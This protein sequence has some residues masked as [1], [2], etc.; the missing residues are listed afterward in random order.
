MKK[1]RGITLIALVITIIVLLILAGVS[2]SLI[3]G[4]QGILERAETSVQKY[5]KAAA[6]EQAELLISDYQVE[7]QEAKYVNRNV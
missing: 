4:E 1:Y 2:L 5:G 3:A 7:F 6:K